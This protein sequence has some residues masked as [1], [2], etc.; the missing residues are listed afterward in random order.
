MALLHFEFES[1]YTGQNEDVN[2]VMPDKTRGMTPAAFYGS[3]KKYPVLWLLHG[4]FGGYSDWIRKSN[5]ETYAC[6]HDCI[7]VMMGVGN[8]DY[9]AWPAFTLGYDATRYVV[10]ELMPIVYN[11]LPASDKREDNFIAGLS[12]GGRGTM[13]FALN[14]PEKFAAAAVLSSCPTDLDGQ[15]AELEALFAKKPSALSGMEL[16]RYNQMHRYDSVDGYLD[17]ISNA[18][19]K[20]DELVAAKADLPR[21]LF[22]IGTEDMA[23]DAMQVF[24]RHAEEIGFPFEYHEGPGRHEWR[25]WER[26]IQIAFRFFGFADEEKGNIF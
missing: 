6:E 7:V 24:R 9:E 19:R 25:V 12:M 22:S 18:W 16:R 15:R 5:V 4:T 23:Y 21:F 26:D 10:D 20:L 8:S 13:T 11:W 17:S 14:Y 3:G 1:E 2:I